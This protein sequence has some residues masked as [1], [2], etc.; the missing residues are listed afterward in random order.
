MAQKFH[1]Y[2][3][4]FR[5]HGLNAKFLGA[6]DADLAVIFHHILIF[7]EFLFEIAAVLM[8]GD[9]LVLVL[10]ELA[11]D[12]FL[13][14]VNGYVHICAFLLGADQ[15]ALDRDGDF[16]LL[17]FSLYAQGYMDFRIRSKIPFQFSQLAFNRL[18]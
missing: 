10:T 17:V 3:G 16:N 18:P 7:K 13:Y 12:D 1:L 5:E 2:T 11:L 9:Q 6:D 8:S 15:S 14:Q 4:V